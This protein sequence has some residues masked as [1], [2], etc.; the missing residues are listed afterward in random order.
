MTHEEYCKE[1]RK[2]LCT[3]NCCG[4]KS[5]FDNKKIKKLENIIESLLA[6]RDALVKALEFYADKLHWD[7]IWVE[8]G[9]EDD[10]GGDAFVRIDD[11]DWDWESDRDGLP[12]GGKL[13]RE[14][15]EKLKKDEYVKS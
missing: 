15:L 3:D 14:T 4:C 8:M 13:A 9:V 5:E 2:S 7:D 1:K 10:D 11:S 12:Y 6:E